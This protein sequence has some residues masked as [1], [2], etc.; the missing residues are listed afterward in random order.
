MRLSDPNLQMKTTFLCEYL[1]Y[2]INR[3]IFFTCEWLWFGIPE[4]NAM[5]WFMRLTDMQLAEVVSARYNQLL[6]NTQ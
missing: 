6:R 3:T 5:K 1:V 2:A 4:S